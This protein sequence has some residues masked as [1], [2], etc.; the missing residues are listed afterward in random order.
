[1]EKKTLWI[2]EATRSAADNG[3]ELVKHV[4]SSKAGCS[5]PSG[6]G[7]LIDLRTAE[8][9]NECFR[10]PKESHYPHGRAK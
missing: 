7:R 9:S 3:R 6:L 10:S 8:F 2:V 5:S 1:M 4:I